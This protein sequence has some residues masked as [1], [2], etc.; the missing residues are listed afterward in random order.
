MCLHLRRIR[1]SV[2]SGEGIWMLLRFAAA[3]A[4]LAIG[5]VGSFDR[6]DAQGYPYVRSPYPPPPPGLERQYEVVPAD[7]AEES[8][9]MLPDPRG[10]A[11][12]PARRQDTYVPPPP[13]FIDP[14]PAPYGHMPGRSAIQR[15]EL[16]PPG[17]AAVPVAPIP[18]A[19][20]VS[21]VP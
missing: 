9:V 8:I 7:D 15:G 3:F 10:G 4:V 12:I 19:P 17:V 5:L 18:A 21:A 16:P 11:M 14:E 6:A 2:P 13:G 1:L 20:G